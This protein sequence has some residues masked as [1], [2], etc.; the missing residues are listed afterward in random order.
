MPRVILHL[1]LDC[2]YAQVEAV[3]LGLSHDEPLAVQQWGSL[4]AVNYA[5]R[6]FGVSRS[7]HI[8]DARKKCPQIH[9]PHVETMG[10]GSVPAPDADLIKN[11]Y[12]D[13]AR[14]KAVLRRYRLASREIFRILTKHAP[15]CEKASI[16]E[17]FLDVTEQALARLPAFR[18]AG[19]ELAFCDDPRNADTTVIG[20]KDTVFPLTEDE[21]LLCVGAAIA[22]EIR[23]EVL[24]MLHYTC[25]VGV[26]SN[27]LVAKLAS[28]MNKPNGQ[29]IISDRF[30]AHFMQT[31]PVDKIRGL[32]GKLGNRVVELGKK[33]DSSE[34]VYAGDILSQY[35]LAGLQSALGPETGTFV[36][37]VCSGDDGN[38]PVNDKKIVAA[39]V[40]AIKSFNQVGP[41]TSMDRIKYWVRV[42]CEEVVL[43]HDEEEVVENHRTPTQFAFNYQRQNDKPMTKRFAAPLKIDVP[44]LTAAIMP[45]LQHA[46]M[47]PCMHLSLV[48]RDFIPVVEKSAMITHFFKEKASDPVGTTDAIKT[49]TS[50]SIPT[51]VKARPAS[52]KQFF[53][54]ASKTHAPVAPKAPAQ[55]AVAKK[56]TPTIA[57]FFEAPQPA[58]GRYCDECRAVVTTSWAEHE[59]FHVAMALQN[60]WRAA[61]PAKKRKG[62]PMDAF[63]KK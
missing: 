48:S 53:G 5:A 26:A 13:R 25:S 51:T 42:L 16:D 8:G 34:R 36:F 62:G 3:R 30:V 50:T 56:A 23:K 49:S 28:P 14:Q 18:A 60:E 57:Q 47:L 33:A 39:Q 4:L 7:D 55:N 58:A 45:L 37:N 10:D 1:D 9:L 44:S 31:F 27:K 52:I 46:N 2:F 59:D 54:Q 15:I 21:E 19:S 61:P 43:R 6:P 12:F 29:T 38:E 17:A 32:G 41:V 24:E 63:V 11:P 22:Q 40:S 20:A 35:G